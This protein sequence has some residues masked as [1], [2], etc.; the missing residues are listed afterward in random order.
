MNFGRSMHRP[1]I[2]CE[3]SKNKS[4]FWF[5]LRTRR[6]KL[7]EL[8]HWIENPANYNDFF[9]GIFSDPRLLLTKIHRFTGEISLYIFLLD[10]K[11][12][13]LRGFFFSSSSSAS[14]SA[15][16]KDVFKDSQL[17]LAEFHIGLWSKFLM[18]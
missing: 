6:T 12:G 13:Q 2:S 4:S 3:I 5:T 14:S 15:S 10:G 1:A 16:S 18:Q 11:F 7:K 17:L 9:K 8:F